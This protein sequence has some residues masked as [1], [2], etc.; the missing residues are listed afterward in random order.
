MKIKFFKNSIWNKDNLES[1]S[2]ALQVPRKQTESKEQ[3]A[4]TNKKIQQKDQIEKSIHPH[5]SK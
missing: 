2:N 5:A 3:S 1:I 4:S